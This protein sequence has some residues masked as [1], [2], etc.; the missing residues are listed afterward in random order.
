[1]ILVNTKKNTAILLI[2][3]SHKS[4][5]HR[6]Y[7]QY[8]P[9]R[10]PTCPLTIHAL[11]HLPYYI[12]TSRPLWTSWAFVM[13]RFCG[14][15]LPAVKNR[16]R[17]Y[18]HLDNYVQRRAQMQIVSLK[19]GLP[20]LA[21]PRIN[22]T[23]ADGERFS[24]RERMYPE[25]KFLFACVHSLW[26]L[27][28]RCYIKHITVNTIILGTPICYNVKM[29]D[30]LMNQMGKYFGLVYA[31]DL[32]LNGAGIRARIDTET[33][34]SYGRFRLT[35]D[36]D[37]FRTAEL[38][39]RHRD[40]RDNSFVRVSQTFTFITYILLIMQLLVRAFT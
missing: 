19:Y 40:A 25:C 13:E 5:P 21:K 24:S 15:I 17:P 23:Y 20:S 31:A 10:L 14:H 35:G 29:D 38:V 32:Q 22:Y 30:R 12:W 37:R 16:V 3:V 36:G 7:Y 6:Y 27:I 26:L 11:L 9:R 28:H 2:L 33:L 8:E 39:E 18:E 34:V 1:M 4:M